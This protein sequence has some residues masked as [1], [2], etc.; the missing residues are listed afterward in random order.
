[1]TTD[2][3]GTERPVYPDTHRLEIDISGTGINSSVDYRAVCDAEPGALC[4]VWCGRPECE[5]GPVD[6]HEDH[7]LS[8]QGECGLVSHLNADPS[9]IPELYDGGPASF[10]PGRIIMHPNSDEVTW[11]YPE[12]AAEDAKLTE[13]TAAERSE[14][15]EYRRRDLAGYVEYSVDSDRKKAYNT[16]GL[17]FESAALLR[18][19]AEKQGA[20]ARVMQRV[21]SAPSEWVPTVR[22]AC[23]ESCLHRCPECR[24]GL[25]THLACDP[26][27][28]YHL[29]A[30]AE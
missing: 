23:E 9:M 6:G 15:E 22:A 14:L 21:H 29:P 30:A 3:A 11:S 28:S 2:H 10:R 19:S 8:D 20:T 5:E 16:I 12:T 1:M 25:V 4:R 24:M 17:N 7:V 13:L 26:Q 27:C 18:N